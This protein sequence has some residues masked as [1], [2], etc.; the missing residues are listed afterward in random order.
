MLLR[1][2]VPRFRTVFQAVPT[3]LQI[4]QPRVPGYVDSADTPRG[5]HGFDRSGFSRIE[6]KFLKDI[7]IDQRQ[8]LASKPVVECL[9][10]MG[11]S[12]SVGH[13]VSSDLDYW[14]CIDQG[15]ISR[16]K[17]DL[18][19]KKLDLITAWAKEKQGIEVTLFTVDLADLATNRLGH[20]GD[21]EPGDILSL[22]LKEEVYRTLLHVVGRIP[23]W[24]AIPL[25]TYA[26]DYRQIVKF[27]DQ[28]PNPN[29]FPQDFIDLGFPHKPPPREYMG[30]ALWQLHK[31]KADPFKA[32]IKTILILEQTESGLRAPLLCDQLKKKVLSSPRDEFPIDPYILM[33]RRVLSFCKD[34]LSPESLELIRTSVYF[35]LYSPLGFRTVD[36][37]SPKVCFLKELLD[38]WGWSQTKVKQMENYIDWPES[39]KL[40]LGE[41]INSLLRELYTKISNRLRADFP[42]EVKLDQDLATL[43]LQMLARYSVHEAKVEDLPSDQYRKSL[44]QTLTLA[45]EQNQW[46]I[47]AGLKKLEM[48]APQERVIYTCNR[49][50]R[51]AAWLIRNRLFTPSLKLVLRPGPRPLSRETFFALLDVLDKYFSGLDLKALSRK[52]TPV[53]QKSG[54][55]LLI[56]NLEEP[57][58]LD[59]IAT[60]EII[61]CTTWGE[62]CHETLDLDPKADN[63]AQ[64]RYLAEKVLDSENVT[65]DDIQFFVVPTM[66]GQE[67]LEI[68]EASFSLYFH[69]RQG[70]LPE[71]KDQP[72]KLRLDID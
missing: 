55:E 13:T 3:L 20:L 51:A 44:P 26:D 59:R 4:N 2:G 42:E 46:S 39:R 15:K 32:A 21:E 17:Q 12:G 68:L 14:V 49:A 60:A 1:Y 56:I 71:I 64:S 22:V 27:L 65:L 67:I 10:L 52:K 36:K 9:F 43:H 25:R 57:P 63:A 34:Q 23:L 40:A 61:Y 31:A 6:L 50:A 19:R 37:D 72:P 11:S 66:A 28:I 7:Q 18:F 58:Q 48:A 69:E 70:T 33:I 30:T 47:F 35:K 45:F 53:P 38:E 54:P 41:G 24:W 5:I 29:F 62:T 8:L 16:K